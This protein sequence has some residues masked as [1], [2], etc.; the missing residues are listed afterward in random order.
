MANTRDR[1]NVG[2][3]RAIRTSS[4]SLDLSEKLESNRVRGVSLQQLLQNLNAFLATSSFQVHPAEGHVRRFKRGVFPQHSLQHRHGFV[5]L[6]ACCQHES[7]IVGSLPVVAAPIDG[8]LKV[9]ERALEI[10]LTAEEDTEVVESLWEV[11]LKRQCLVIE[12]VGLSGFA[13]LKQGEA[14]I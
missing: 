9:R 3:S 11:G 7:Q 6:A 2:Q 12:L 4:P 13:S 8:V 10:P 5:R 14:Q 1:A